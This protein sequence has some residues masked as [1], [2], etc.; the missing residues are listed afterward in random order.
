MEIAVQGITAGTVGDGAFAARA[1]S[2][3]LADSHIGHLCSTV[4]GTDRTIRFPR[5]AICAGIASRRGCRAV[6][7][8]GITLRTGRTISKISL[9]AGTQ[10]GV[11]IEQI[12]AVAGHTVGGRNTRQ[13]VVRAFCAHVVAATG[14]RVV[15]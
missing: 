3:A 15:A 8:A 9:R 7:A 4:I 10:T 12:A 14:V 1:A 11:Y 6:F 13:T 5:K 2:I